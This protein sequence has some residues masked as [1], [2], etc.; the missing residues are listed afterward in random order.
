MLLSRPR[1]AQSPPE[2]PPSFVIVSSSIEIRARLM[3]PFNMEQDAGSMERVKSIKKLGILAI[4][5]QN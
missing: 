1:R 2:L 5:N 3:F 4:V